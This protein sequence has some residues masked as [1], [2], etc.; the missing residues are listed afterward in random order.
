LTSNDQHSFHHGRFTSPS[1]LLQSLAN[2]FSVNGIVK[3]FKKVNEDT[4]YVWSEDSESIRLLL[5]CEE[6]YQADSNSF[7]RLKDLACSFPVRSLLPDYR[8]YVYSCPLWEEERSALYNGL[9]ALSEEGNRI[10]KIYT[11]A[12]NWYCTRINLLLAFDH[13][14][15]EYATYTNLLNECIIHQEPKWKTKVYR[16]ALH[17]PLE[18]FS[19]LF[20]HRF[21]IPSFVSTSRDEKRKFWNPFRGLTPE[22]EIEVRRTGKQPIFQNVVFEIDLS[23]YYERSTIIQ[24]HQTDFDEEEVLLASYN[25]YEWIGYEWRDGRPIIKLKVLPYEGNVEEGEEDPKTHKKEIRV[26]GARP[27]FPEAFIAKRGVGITERTVSPEDFHLD[28]RK[29]VCNYIRVHKRDGLPDLPWLNAPCLDQ[30]VPTA[31]AEADKELTRSLGSQRS[32]G[33]K[34]SWR[35]KK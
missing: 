16:G 3:P 14:T 34:N 33:S 4:L 11:S 2:Y 24:K 9:M 17:S 30:W 1:P 26:R 21:F 27:E 31:Y 32:Q 12:S 25:L 23:E 5:Y 13:L 10:I 18:I 7:H 35:G 20:K 28:F 8:K 6:F 22:E 19:F 29:L 15:G